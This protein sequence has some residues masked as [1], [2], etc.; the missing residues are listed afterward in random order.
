M[1]LSG[2]TSLR[3]NPTVFKNSA[4]PWGGRTVCSKQRALSHGRCAGV[5]V[6]GEGVCKLLHCLCTHMFE[7]GVT[8]LALL[9]F[10]LLPT[11]ESI[12]SPEGKGGSSPAAV[13]D[14]H[15][16]GSCSRCS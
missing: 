2:Y 13:C 1:H 4:A 6:L 12:C 7:K 10:V 8:P 5:E 14:D 11:Q 16:A 3:M 9:C 15:N